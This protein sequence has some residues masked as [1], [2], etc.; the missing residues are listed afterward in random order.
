MK[1]VLGIALLFL[2]VT[3]G[4][5]HDPFRG[6]QPTTTNHAGGLPHQEDPWRY[7]QHQGVWTGWH[8]K[9]HVTKTETFKSG[10]LVK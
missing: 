3:C 5:S 6:G 10:E 4:E 1:K 9:G 2:L 8:E 7:N